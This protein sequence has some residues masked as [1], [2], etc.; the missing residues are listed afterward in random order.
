MVGP[1]VVSRIEEAYRSPSYPARHPFT[2][3]PVAVRTGPSV[4]VDVVGPVPSRPRWH[5]AQTPLDVLIPQACG[6]N[7]LDMEGVGGRKQAVLTGIA[8]AQTYDRA[9]VAIVWAM[10]GAPTEDSYAA[11]KPWMEHQSTRS[12]LTART[13]SINAQLGLAGVYGTRQ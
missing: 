8:G 2:L 3:L 11:L 5:A 10:D 9:H 13:G 1:I 6:D 12:R 4:I 7:V